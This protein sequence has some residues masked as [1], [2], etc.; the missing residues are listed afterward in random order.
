MD[1]PLNAADLKA[2]RKALATLRALDQQLELAAK[3][4]I[5]VDE[6]VARQTH[7]KAVGDGI[8]E[9]YG[10]MLQRDTSG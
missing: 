10:P 1:I 8:I 9:T 7:L 4:G 3:A 2:V 5:D 6:Q